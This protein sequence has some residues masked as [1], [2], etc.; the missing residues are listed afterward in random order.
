MGLDRTI[1]TLEAYLGYTKGFMNLEI[2]D[3]IYIA[4]CLFMFISL[5]ISFIRAA[6]NIKPNAYSELIVGNIIYIVIALLM[7]YVP[8]KSGMDVS[9]G[10]DLLSYGSAVLYSQIFVIVL[11]SAFMN[12]SANNLGK[13]R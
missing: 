6:S 7:W 11:F 1:T 10:M 12:K 8:G 13:R 5:L 9:E 2:V 3:Q 4:A